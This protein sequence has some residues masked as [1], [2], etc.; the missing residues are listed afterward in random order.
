MLDNIDIFVDPKKR[1]KNFSTLNLE[2]VAVLKSS[3]DAEH[4]AKEFDRIFLKL[5]RLISYSTRKNNSLKNDLE[6]DTN[7]LLKKFLNYLKLKALP[8]KI[9]DEQH[10]FFYDI[11]WFINFFDGDTYFTKIH[12][13]FPKT[14]LREYNDKSISEQF[15]QMSY[16]REWWIKWMPEW[17]SCSY[18]TVLLYNFFNKLKE[19]WL[20]MDIKF[21][22]FKK[23]DNTIIDF[24]AMRHSW[25]I[26]NF[27]W[28]DYF[29]DHEWIQ[30][31]WNEEPI[32][33]KLQ[34]YI[35]L[36]N[37]IPKYKKAADFFEN[38]KHWNME[39]TDQVIFFDNVSDFISHYEEN[40]GYQRVAFYVN[41]WENKMP[42]KINFEFVNNWIWIAVN[43]HWHV[44]YLNDNK[45]NKSWFPWNIIDKI[46]YEKDSSWVHKITKEGKELF[47]E[48]FDAIKDK[49]NAD[50]LYQNYTSNWKWKNII[51]DYWWKNG[52]YMLKEV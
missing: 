19:A 7:N 28:E 22:R 33:R 17:W 14:T 18:W 27:Q 20:D 11:C 44:Y 40:P 34:P 30:I 24:P 8:R 43:W 29:V 3:E 38:F 21:F 39:E 15:F 47:R 46:A 13:G 12:N 16:W 26:I 42:D 9:K 4:I 49:I 35:D 52:V 23:L 31:W 10:A 36:S 32:I 45:I 1:N 50:W 25:L 51:A 2:E 5:Q 37:N 48:F 41:R 6:E